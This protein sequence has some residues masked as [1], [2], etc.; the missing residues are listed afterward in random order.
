MD[1]WNLSEL[2]PAAPGYGAIYGGAVFSDRGRLHAPSAH[3][4]NACALLG[5]FTPE[6]GSCVT[7]FAGRRRHWPSF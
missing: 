6:S 5:I 7:G 3:L 2:I 1:W 4:L